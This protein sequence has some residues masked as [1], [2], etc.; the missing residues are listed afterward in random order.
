MSRERT[1][2]V[3]GGGQLG[4]YFV[5]SAQRLGLDTVVLD[6]VPGGP[7]GA[8]AH[9]QITAAYDDTRA[10]ADLARRCCAVTTEFENV[11]ADALRWL[12]GNTSD[13]TR[14]APGADAVAISQDRL[15]EKTF[16]A[17]CGLPTAPW[18][19]LKAS[20]DT[21]QRQTQLDQ[22]AGA[23]TFPALLKTAR[24]GYDGK[25]Q[26]SVNSAADL[27]AAWAQ[28]GHADAILEQRLALQQEISVLVARDAHGASVCWPV[29]VNHH[30]GGILAHTRVGFALV[31]P[32]LADA[33]RDAARR[34]AQALDYCGV[35]CIEFFCV[36]DAAAPGGQ[37]LV[38]NEMAPRPHNSGHYS[39]DACDMSQFDAQARVLAGWSLPEPQL[40]APAVMLNLLG[41][42]WWGADGR[43]REPDWSAIM[44]W[45]GVH[46]H[47][48]GKKDAQPG[49]KMG[50]I[51]VTAPRAADAQARASQIARHLG[52]AGMESL[53]DAA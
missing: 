19:A 44:G 10:W 15:R 29:Q 2:G 49:R 33:A 41:D 25:G 3:M 36:A 14:V 26:I 38:V 40:L 20:A 9:Q 47:L 45:G 43:L 1:V 28:L 50:H 52:L 32:A 39:I 53:H 7:A 18:A 23:V 21:A 4:R 34:I 24:L 37:R 16:F 11:P 22:A 17:D 48:Y 13:P 30:H 46:L 31:A 5:Q 35:L 8:I 51:T 6:P 27:A 12:A 42:A